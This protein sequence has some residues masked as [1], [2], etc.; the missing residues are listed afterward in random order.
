MNDGPGTDDS[1]FSNFDTVENRNGG[2]DPDIVFDED[3]AFG[4]GGLV[5]DG[6]IAALIGVGTAGDHIEL[7][8]GENVLADFNRWFG[9]NNIAGADI[10]EI[11]DIDIAAFAAQGG[12]PAYE[13]IVTDFQTG[14]M[15]AFGID[16][17]V[18][19]ENHIIADLDFFSVPDGHVPAENNAPADFFKEFGEKKFS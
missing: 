5:P 18:I 12:I 7:P 15:F 6:D 17:G 3:A 9:D 14:I 4:D 8:C 10:G 11:A 2:A 13:D 19:V 16:N 1:A